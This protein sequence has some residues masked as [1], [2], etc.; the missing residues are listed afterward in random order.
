MIYNVTRKALRK[1]ASAMAVYAELRS[2]ITPA[3]RHWFGKRQD[4]ADGAG[5]SPRTFDSAI[6]TLEKLGLVD[7]QQRYVPRGWDKKDESK[8]SSVQTKMTPIQLPNL[9]VV[10]DKPNRVNAGQTGRKNCDTPLADIALTPSKKQHTDIDPLE[11]DPWEGNAP[12]PSA[13]AAFDGL[14]ALA[15]AH[16]A[17][18]VSDQYGPLRCSL[19]PN[20][21]PNDDPCWQCRTVKD[22]KTAR[23]AAHA[24]EKADLQRTT[25]QKRRAGLD[26]CPICDHNGYRYYINPRTGVEGTT[27]CHHTDQDRAEDA[28]ARA[29]KTANT[30][31]A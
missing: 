21:N 14:D 8:I 6:K 1:E 4:L 15:A 9:Y 13:P 10:Y 22:A 5:I 18:P 30:N 31:A 11:V 27:L 3:R 20:G 7:V 23:D 2:H 28:Q 26:S 29:R 17:R 12:A 19:H 24:K 25:D 16:A